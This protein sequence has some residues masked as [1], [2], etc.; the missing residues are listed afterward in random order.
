[1]SHHFSAKRKIKKGQRK[2][3]IRGKV[4]KAN[5]GKESTNSSNLLTVFTLCLTT[6]IHTEL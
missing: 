1:M 5:E 3:K 2:A 4:R 6:K